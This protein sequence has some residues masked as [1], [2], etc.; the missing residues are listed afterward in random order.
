MVPKEMADLAREIISGLTEKEEVNDFPF[1]GDRQIEPRLWEA[2]RQADPGEITA[3]ALVEYDRGRKRLRCSVSE[4]GCFVLSRNRG[5][6]SAGALGAIFQMIFKLNLVI[7]HY[8]LYARN[9]PLAN[10]WVSEKDLPG[11]GLFFTA[12]ARA[13]G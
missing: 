3:R 1:A 4:H 11:G 5:N 9:K 7:L 13:S 12:F 8:L 10:K 2:L 6:R